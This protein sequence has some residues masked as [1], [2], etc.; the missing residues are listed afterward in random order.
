MKQ[1]DIFSILLV[2]SAGIL[3]AF[4]GCNAILG[5]P[6]ERTASFRVIEPISN[7]LATPNPETF[8][9]EAINPTIEVYVGDCQDVDRNGI[10]DRA[11]LAACGK[12]EPMDGQERAEDLRSPVEEEKPN[13]NGGDS[14]SLPN[15]GGQ[16]QQPG[17]GS[18]EGQQPNNEGGGGDSGSGNEEEGE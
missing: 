1:S 11:E 6:D 15:N 7:S 16:E 13:D 5:N 2:S 17:G 10:L 9:P 4:F 12:A 3:I 14:G 18:Q 8:N